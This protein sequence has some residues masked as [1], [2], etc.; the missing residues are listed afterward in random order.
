MSFRTYVAL[1]SALVLHSAVFP[2]AALAQS[3][4]PESQA[5]SDE[6]KKGYRDVLNVTN[7]FCMNIYP[8]PTASECLERVKHGIGGAFD[9]HTQYMNAEETKKFN[10]QSTGA[11][12][13]GIGIEISKPAGQPVIVIS[14]M[15]GTPAEKA[16]LLPD[17]VI[18]GISK[19]S[20][21]DFV[22]TVSLKNPDEVVKLVRGEIGSTVTLKVR[23]AGIQNDLIVPVK[24][25]TIKIAQIKG[26]LLTVG[27]KTYALIQNKVYQQKNREQLA[28][29]FQELKKL[30][31]GKLSGVIL[32]SENNPGGLLNEVA[33]E[34]D[35]FL[36][37]ESILL[38]RTNSGITAMDQSNYFHT[39]GD[40]TDGLPMLVVV[41]A[42]CAS[43]C[44][45][46]AANMKFHHRALI[47]GTSEATFGKGIVQT[48]T[49]G[50]DGSAIKYTSSEY[51]VG[52]MNN[53]VPVQCIGVKPDIVFSYP[54]VKE[55][56]RISECELSEHVLSKGPMENPPPFKPLQEVNPAHYAAGL[57]MLEAYK[58]HMLP[59]VQKDDARRKEFLKSQQQ[60]E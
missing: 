31:K 6:L 33:A 34:V 40:I 28:A 58:A 37:A 55:Q 4:D 29:K 19:N 13:A 59:K 53:W 9:P 15:E 12:Y 47:A 51:L 45:V 44:E 39:P 22:S 27:N 8:R 11:G 42:G 56:K 23:R 46:F 20:G 32:S 5:Y 35:L 7:F 2:P 18:I 10:D 43:A 49:S 14:A 41:N 26:E 52:S 54:G 50:G 48:W 57:E 21:T 16:G 60:Q 25:D 36:D 30:A 38:L 17:D 24:R 1:M 3:L